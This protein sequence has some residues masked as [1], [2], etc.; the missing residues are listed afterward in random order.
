MKSFDWRF[1]INYYPDLRKAG[2]NTEEKARTHYKVYGIKENRRTHQII[3]KSDHIPTL[4]ATDILSHINQIHVSKGLFM[5][6]QRIQHKYQ[7]ASYTNPNKPSLF[8]GVYTDDDLYILK[9]HNSIK[10]I[11]WGGEDANPNLQHSLATLN[12][13]KMLHNTVHISI[14]KCIYKRLASQNISSI[15]IDFN[16]VD[17]LLF[18]P[19]IKKGNCIFIFNG[20]TPGREYVYGNQIYEKVIKLLP[21]FEYIFSNQLNE[22]YENMPKIYSQCFIGLRL[23]KY[24]GNA[25]TVQEFE[26][27]KIPIIHNQSDYGLKWDKIDNIINL[28]NY[29]FKH[30]LN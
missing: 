8:F 16:L 14:S 12:E 25:N 5:F 24:D 20:Q 30:Q 18:K 26:A 4:P 10:Y 27:M 28:I 2:I 13:I 17:T 9:H 1:Y 6:Q 23:T 11:I 21:Q 3:H 29:H 19:V 7:I 15:L 22:K